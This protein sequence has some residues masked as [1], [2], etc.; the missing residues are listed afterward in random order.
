MWQV[1]STEPINTVIFF[2]Y[3]QEP[4]PSP[5]RWFRRT[6]SFERNGM[7]N[8]QTPVFNTRFIGISF[9]LLV[10]WGYTGWQAGAW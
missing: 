2:E 5:A 8:I 1:L 10:G 6:T 9:F 7:F 3:L 4:I